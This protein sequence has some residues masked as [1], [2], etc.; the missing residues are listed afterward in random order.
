MPIRILVCITTD[1]ISFIHNIHYQSHTFDK[2]YR[3]HFRGFCRYFSWQEKYPGI[4]FHVTGWRTD[5]NT[6]RHYGTYPTYVKQIHSVWM[7][8]LI[9]SPVF[10]CFFNILRNFA[11]CNISLAKKMSR[12]LNNF[13]YITKC[14]QK[15]FKRIYF[16]VSRNWWS[17]TKCFQKPFKRIW[18]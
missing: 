4:I 3:A 10:Y 5:R 9:L 8:W 11:H 17:I 14:F 18:F 7:F 13:Y 12:M 16:S 15:P 2:V 1:Y 6:E